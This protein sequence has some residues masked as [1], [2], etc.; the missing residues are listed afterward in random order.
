[1]SRKFVITLGLL[2]AVAF[3]A[4]TSGMSYRTLFAHGH[5]HH[6]CEDCGH[7]V[8]P[9][10]CRKCEECIARRKAAKETAKKCEKCGHEECTGNCNRC[11]DCLQERV[12]K[13]EKETEKK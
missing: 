12:K 4:G 7:Y 11:V 10:D 13:L 8:C 5:G 3:A 6:S 1:M 9:G 2:I